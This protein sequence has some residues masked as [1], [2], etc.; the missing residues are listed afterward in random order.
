MN[1]KHFFL[2]A[3]AI[4]VGTISY[5]E[6]HDCKKA[7]WPPRIIAA[8]LVFGLLDLVALASVELGGVLAIGVVLAALVNKG[9]IK[10]C[11]HYGTGNCQCTPQPHSYQFIGPPSV[12]PPT[13][14]P[15]MPPGSPALPP[16]TPG[17]PPG[18][19]PALPGGGQ[20]QLP[21]GG[22]PELPAGGIAV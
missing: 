2:A 8:G 3:W 19:P 11:Q 22:V 13:V 12:V 6:I 18:A 1:A 17:L 21:P 10:D 4:T 5:H 14:P 15:F 9:F 20:P 7:P 16:G